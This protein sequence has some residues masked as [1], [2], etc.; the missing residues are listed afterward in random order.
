FESKGNIVKSIYI[1]HYIL[2]N[3]NHAYFNYPSGLGLI[4][5]Q[6]VEDMT[7]KSFI[8]SLDSN[9]Y[10]NNEKIVLKEIF[11]NHLIHRI[12][13]LYLAW[14]I[15]QKVVSTHFYTSLR[16]KNNAFMSE[17][18][19]DYDIFY[20]SVHQNILVRHLEF[21]KQ[22]SKISDKKECTT[23]TKDVNNKRKSAEKLFLNS[24]GS[25]LDDDYFNA[26]VDYLV[27]ISLPINMCEQKFR[28]LERIELNRK[29]SE[30]I[31]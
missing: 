15:D 19:L 30:R 24:E 21:Y 8:Q 28:L 20:R 31:K 3:M 23:L 22:I 16:D 14:A 6:V 4:Y 17:E 11:E 9:K 1:Y 2:S 27:Y 5:R 7:V 18:A 25:A 26:S 12:E 13:L 29:L 10:S